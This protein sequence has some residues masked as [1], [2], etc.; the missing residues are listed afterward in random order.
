MTSDTGIASILG[1]EKQGEK[2]QPNGYAGLDASGNLLANEISYQS[3]IP[4]YVY[5]ESN[6]PFIDDAPTYANL[7]FA[8]SGHYIA[9][10]DVL[11]CFNMR[12]P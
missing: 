1:F 10:D 3:V 9:F 7:I 6:I 5:V 11:E 8:A 4:L 12:K 2:N